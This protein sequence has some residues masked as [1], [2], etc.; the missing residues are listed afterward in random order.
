[1][2]EKGLIERNS[3]EKDARVKKL[4]L[5]KKGESLVEEVRKEFQRIENLLSEGL[6]EEELEQF[7]STLYKMQQNML[8]DID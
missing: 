7:F 5:S 2:E 4:Q 6:T 3:I 1:M 8:K